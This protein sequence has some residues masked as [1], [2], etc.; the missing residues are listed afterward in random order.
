MSDVDW[1]D[2]ALCAGK[3]Q[4]VCECTARVEMR[5]KRRAREVTQYKGSGSRDFL[6]LR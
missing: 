5:R 1:E 2:G 6:V 3:R 4:I